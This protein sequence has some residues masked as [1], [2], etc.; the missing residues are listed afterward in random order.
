[1]NIYYANPQFIK[2]ANELQN[3]ICSYLPPHPIVKEIKRYNEN[4]YEDNFLKSPFT[5]FKEHIEHIDKEHCEYP[6]IDNFTY[7][8]LIHLY[9]RLRETDKYKHLNSQEAHTLFWNDFYDIDDEDTVYSIVEM[10]KPIK[11]RDK[12]IVQIMDDAIEGILIK[13]GK[14]EI[15]IKYTYWNGWYDDQIRTYDNKYIKSIIKMPDDHITKWKLC[16][17]CNSKIQLHSGGTIK[18]CENCM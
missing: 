12:V 10:L 16:R 14:Y 6:I 11:K 15:T 2:L 18:A 1:M 5:S 9:L 4:Y 13:K 17:I 8:D 3:K 7:I